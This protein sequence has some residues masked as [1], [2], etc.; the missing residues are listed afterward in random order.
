[1]ER[2]FSVWRKSSRSSGGDNCVEISH[3]SHGDVG[4]RDSKDKAGPV[5]TFG[6]KAWHAFIDDVRNGEFG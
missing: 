4:M 3:S 2:T 6:A 1:M 5:L